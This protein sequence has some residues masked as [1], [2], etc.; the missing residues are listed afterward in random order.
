MLL[1]GNQMLKLLH[2]FENV[3]FLMNV[4]SKKGRSRF[5]VLRVGRVISFLLDEISSKSE[6]NEFG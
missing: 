3:S 1:I 5:R 4:I 6:D 2:L